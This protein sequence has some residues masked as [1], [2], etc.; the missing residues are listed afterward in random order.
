M[1]HYAKVTAGVVVQVI[2]AEDDFFDT[3]ID[4]SPGKWIKTSYNTSRGIH[5]LG[6]TPLRMNYAG[7]G[8]AYDIGRDAFIPPKRF[9]SWV[10]EE[11]TCTYIAP[12]EFP[13]DGLEYDW[14]EELLKW[15]EV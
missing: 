10:L 7:E 2:V 12:V 4:T 3:F 9:P 15:E 1:A 11:A 5:K 6:G 8:Y 13:S 14:N